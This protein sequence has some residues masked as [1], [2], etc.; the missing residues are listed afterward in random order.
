MATRGRKLK[1]GLLNIQSVGN[2]T[3]EIRSLINDEKIDIL[4]LTETWLGEYDQSKIMEMTP[5]THTFVHVPR[6]EKKGGGVGLV[7]SKSCKKIKLEHTE[8]YTSFELMKVSCDLGP[9]KSVFSVVYRP[10]N[11]NFRIFIDE[12]RSYL[13]T[14]DMVSV[15]TYIC[16]D[17]N[18]WMDNKENYTTRC[19][20]D[21]MKSFNLTNKV[22]SSTSVGGHILDL[23]FCDSDHNLVYEVT[24]DEICRISPV[25]KLVT[26][27]IPCEENVS[28]SKKIVFRKKND[29][30]PETL[31]NNVIREIDTMK[32]NDCSHND[33][34][35]KCATCLAKLYNDVMKKEYDE[36]CPVKEKN[37][38]VR[39]N[40]PWYNNEIHLAKKEK[41]KKERQWRQLRTDIA[42]REYMDKRNKFNKLILKRKR[43]YYR[44][45]TLESK[46]NIG[47]LYKIL[48]GLTGNKKTNVLPEGYD[49]TVLA[50]NFAQFFERKILSIVENFEENEANIPITMTMTQDKLLSFKEVRVD[51][52]KEIVRKLNITYCDRDPLPISDIIQSDKF[53]DILNVFTSIINNSFLNNMFPTSEKVALIKPIIKGKLDKQSLSS[54]RPVSNL[55]FLSKVIE[56]VVLAQLMKHLQSVQ[57][58]PDEQSAYRKLYSTETAMCSVINDLVILMDEGKCGL[59]ILLDLSAAF[60]TVVH[61]LLLLDCKSVGIDGDAIT[62][63]ESYLENRKYCVQVGRSFSDKK[64]LERGVPQGSVLGPVLFCIYTIELSYILKKYDINFKLFADDTQFYMTLNNVDQA[65]EKI[66]VIMNE[67][68]KWMESKQLKLNQDKT[69]CLLVGK[70]R[71][72]KRLNMSTLCI[73][74]RNL[75]VCDAVKNLGVTLDST[76]S[77]KEHIQQVVRTTNYHLRNIAFIKKYL[78]ETT[79][80]MLVQN[81]VITKLDYCNSLYYGMPNYLLKELQLIMNRAARLIKGVPPRERITPA[82]IELHWLPIKARIEYK[83]DVMTH[84]AL[85]SGKPEY[86]RKMLENFHHDNIMELRH[87]TDPHRLLEPRSN[88]EIGFRAFERCAPRLYN[89]LPTELKDCSKMDIFKKQLKTYLFKEAYDFNGMEIRKR[90]SC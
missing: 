45:K 90:Y 30:V 2:K 66:E 11:Q 51:Q 7:I 56:S 60:D 34:I 43:E 5:T 70:N 53:S 64:T 31:I 71:D 81:H 47:K 86:L 84:Q 48:D 83:I 33:Q 61:K 55:T 77:M 38:L 37:I 65:K 9:R 6:Q 8:K 29:L 88:L 52:I 23:V 44:Q 27:Q 74:G 50:N 82:L 18:I 72:I 10:P 16:G 17:F 57:A 79:M 67:V 76:L 85:Q 75:D 20:Q 21:M 12:F 13:E 63:I 32:N 73:N 25:H 78:D 4:A 22:E 46:T 26:F 19:F 80:K 14:L 40:A 1:C 24:V 62:F 49:D 42:K 35:R 58:L 3:I 69:E 89:K 54:F 68:G 41:R 39:D 28:Y 15:N 36:M 59:L 87:D